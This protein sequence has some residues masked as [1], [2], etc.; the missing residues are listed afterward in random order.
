MYGA[1]RGHL[2]DSTAFLYWFVAGTGYP[3]AVTK[4]ITI[5]FQIFCHLLLSSAS[6]FK[7]LQVLLKKS[8]SICRCFVSLVV[9]PSIFPSMA[10][11]HVVTV[12]HVS[13][14]V[15]FTWV[16]VV[17]VCLKYSC[18]FSCTIWRTA[19]DTLSTHVIF[20]FSSILTFQKLVIFRY[21]LGSLSMS[22][23]QSWK[24]VIFG[25]PYDPSHSRPMTHWPIS[26][27]VRP[28]KLQKAELVK[29]VPGSTVC[30][31]VCSRYNLRLLLNSLKS[32]QPK[33]P[34]LI[35]GR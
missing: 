25:D 23:P 11:C 24:W 31:K 13:R 17:E 14:C 8:L 26:I 3:D 7:S 1:L 2:C 18:K 33:Q 19:F 16:F 10:L 20:N 32:L 9:V 34:V 6:L 12:I 5:W 15:L 29:R 35:A 4:F 22:R 21:Q 28:H 27:S 30:R